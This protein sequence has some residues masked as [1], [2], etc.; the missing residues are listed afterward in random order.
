MLAEHD[1]ASAPWDEL[2]GLADS[3]RDRSRALPESVARAHFD[4]WRTATGS[5]KWQSGAELP[6]GVVS[7]PLALVPRVYEHVR[8]LRYAMHRREHPAACDCAALVASGI[9]RRPA[10]AEL[11]AVGDTS[12][13]YYF[14]TEYVCRECESRWFC[15]EMDDDSNGVFWDPFVR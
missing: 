2:Q 5:Y 6:R 7:V 10:S 8:D 14:G 13:G 11:E 15:G 3:F 4:W 12:D 1:A 9:R